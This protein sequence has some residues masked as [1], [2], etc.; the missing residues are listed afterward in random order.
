MVF[1]LFQHCEFITGALPDDW[2]GASEL[3]ESK[4]EKEKEDGLKLG[5]TI[6]IVCVAVVIVALLG[7]IIYKKR[8]G[9]TGRVDQNAPKDHSEALQLDADGSALQE[10]VNSMNSTPSMKSHSSYHDD[11]SVEVG[12]NDE[13][14]M[15]GNGHSHS[16]G[17][18]SLI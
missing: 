7:Y 2:P 12:P 11:G 18:Q 9:G 5:V 17:G 14:M 13:H 3:E 1:L 4:A 8:R 6:A 15:N 16:N 10:V